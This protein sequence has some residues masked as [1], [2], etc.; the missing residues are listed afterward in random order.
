MNKIR[1]L[2]RVLIMTSF[3]TFPGFANLNPTPHSCLDSLRDSHGMT[4]KMLDPL[5]RQ[6][7][8]KVDRFTYD[9][10]ILDPVDVYAGADSE[11]VGLSDREK[12][13]LSQ[14]MFRRFA[15]TLS[16]R[17]ELTHTADEGKTLRVHLILAGA[18]VS[19]VVATA[20]TWFDY[21]GGLYNFV[22]GL[23]GGHS[24]YSGS[25]TY[26]VEIFDAANGNLIEAMIQFKNIVGVE[27][28]IYARSIDR[29]GTTTG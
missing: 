17:F 15:S 22:Q 1:G 28:C 5:Q 24:A 20:V 12:H 27:G 18:E 16:Q 9:R 21:A 11:F 10:L 23:F 4:M 25:V 2:R 3:I 14:Y 13:E 6:A 7:A 8:S 29:C 19:P 26:A